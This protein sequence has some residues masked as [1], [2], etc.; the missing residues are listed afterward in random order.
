MN[1]KNETKALT[2]DEQ[3]A[4]LLG[5][6]ERQEKLSGLVADELK[7]IRELDA[8]ATDSKNAADQANGQRNSIWDNVKS[9]VFK[10]HEATKDAPDTRHQVFSDLM[11]EFLNPKGG[12]A[13]DKVKLST[14]GQYA[15]TGRKFLVT[16][17]TDQGH[18]PEE[19]SEASVKDVR[20]AFKDGKVKAR[21]KALAEPMKHLRYAAKHATDAEWLLI[22]TVTGAIEALYNPIK[23]R[24]DR[25]SK[26]GEAA[27]AIP[28][29][30]QQSPAEPTT[31]E[32]VA[33][34]IVNADQADDGEG[35]KQQAV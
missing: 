33:G 2:L 12:V 16:V 34:E 21:N 4:V 9:I 28:E 30:Q 18:E 31:A 10:V 6:K 3:I 13:A 15:S 29:L 17:L 32:T 26:K 7:A 25:S 24:R 22:A 5:L 23:A 20:E 8:Q 35:I 19:Y 1:A 14:A 11:D 27:R